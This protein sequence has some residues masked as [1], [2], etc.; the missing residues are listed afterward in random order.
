LRYQAFKDVPLKLAA[1]FVMAAVYLL[2]GANHFLH[3][4]PYKSIIPRIL[5]YH[6]A[7]VYLSGVL[8]ML[9]ALLLIPVSTRKWG[10]WG[11]ILLL[12]AVFPA[13]IQMMLDYLHQHRPH[14][15]VTILRIPVQGLL[16]WWASLYLNR[17]Q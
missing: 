1:L 3:P 7:L 17:N 16:I 10:A 12:V 8:E 2:A 15:W 14:A 6:D 5:P 11:I 13:N 9:F 4:E